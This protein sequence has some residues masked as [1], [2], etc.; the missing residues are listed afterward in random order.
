[1]NG[2]EAPTLADRLT[3]LGISSEAYRE[4]IDAQREFPEYL[5]AAAIQDLWIAD[6]LEH[7]QEV[8]H[9]ARKYW[10]AAALSPSNL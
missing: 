10:P 8:V 5:L 2:T 7:G 6:S 9:V 3:A 4:S 1:M